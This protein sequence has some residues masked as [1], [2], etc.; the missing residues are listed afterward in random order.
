MVPQPPAV[1]RYSNQFYQLL[2]DNSKKEKLKQGEYG[3][4][5]SGEYLVFR[6][7]VSEIFKQLKV[8]QSYYSRVRK[9]LRENGCV[10]YL[11]QGNRAV[12]SVI[13]LHKPPPP[14]EEI[15]AEDLTTRPTADK[16]LHRLEKLESWRESQKGIDIVEALQNIEARLLKL[17]K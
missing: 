5:K 9:L 7:S 1:I 2:L 14:P 8:S 4:Q 15:L 6:G 10:S 13:V 17:E 12:A 3:L 16:L 11:E